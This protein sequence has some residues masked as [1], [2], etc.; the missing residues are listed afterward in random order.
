MSQAACPRKGRCFSFAFSSPLW[1]TPPTPRAHQF[2]TAWEEGHWEILRMERAE[3][4]ALTIA[5]SLTSSV[6]RAGS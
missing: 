1:S 3:V 2:N 5:A 6:A 4:A